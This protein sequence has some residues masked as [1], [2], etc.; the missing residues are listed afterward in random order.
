MEVLA[1]A[2]VKLFHREILQRL[3]FGRRHRLHADIADNQQRGIAPREL[4]ITIIKAIDGENVVVP[5]VNRRQIV[6]HVRQMKQLTNLEHVS[7]LQRSGDC[8]HHIR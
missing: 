4:L 6:H 5:S 2:L 1:E 8:V 3:D 7:T